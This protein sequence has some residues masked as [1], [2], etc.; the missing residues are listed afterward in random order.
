MPLALYTCVLCLCTSGLWAIQAETS[1]AVSGID[2]PHRDLAPTNL[3]FA[4]SLYRH[5]LASAP[6]T[7]VFI[8]PVSISI[9]LA[10]LSLGTCGHT[11]TQLLQGLGFN[12]TRMSETKIHQDFQHLLDLLRES[13]TSLEMAMGNALFLNHSLHPRESFS[14]DI[15][16]YYKS[17]AL[18]VDFQDWTRARRQ[19]NEYINNKT[20][21]KLTDMF[22]ELDSP[23]ILILVNYIF[24]RG[25]WAH[26]F[27]S[28]SSREENFYVN[29]T[30]TVTVPMMSKSGTIMYLHDSVL[31]CQLVQLNFTGNATVFFILPDQGQ[32]DT[33]IAGLSRDTI[34]RW[35]NSLIHG[36]VDLYL[37]KLSISGAYDLRAM[38]ADMGIEDLFTNRANFSGITQEAPLMLSRVVHKAILQIDQDRVNA[39]NPTGSTP[40]LESEPVTL[41]L[42]WPFLVLIFDHY[43]W[44]PL[45]LGKVVNP[46]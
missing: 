19:I 45:L 6:D 26:P 2:S 8:S 18:A 1:S 20:Q 23:A 25:T 17:E 29:K 33:V 14:A 22:S 37:P 35:S 9:A 41:R 38:L 10:M 28:E 39:A 4:L 32:M 31:P 40:K 11:Q 5:V 42:N 13:D 36:Q 34:L 12:L 46:S 7:N 30:T 44:S 24:F 43:T 16:H 15:K 21:G 3:D 27:N